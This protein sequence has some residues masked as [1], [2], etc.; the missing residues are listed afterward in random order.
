MVVVLYF[1]PEIFCSTFTTKHL[2][3]FSSLS[4]LLQHLHVSGVITFAPTVVSPGPLLPGQGEV[5]PET[6]QGSAGVP[7]A[8]AVPQYILS[9]RQRSSEGKKGPSEAVPTRE[10]QSTSRVPPSA[11]RSER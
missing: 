6:Q 11:L 10:H 9:R 2:Y 8:A 4:L 3:T 1:L 5:R 7:P